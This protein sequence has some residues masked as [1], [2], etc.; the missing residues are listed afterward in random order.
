MS[1]YII[2]FKDG[3][4]VIRDGELADVYTPNDIGSL[5]IKAHLIED[6]HIIAIWMKGQQMRCELIE[7]AV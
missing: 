3:Q 7:E 4:T 1:R 5:P 2:K 6:V